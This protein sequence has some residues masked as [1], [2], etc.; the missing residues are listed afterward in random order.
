LTGAGI[1]LALAIGGWFVWG[2]TRPRAECGKAYLKVILKKAGLDIRKLPESFFDECVAHAEGCVSSYALA[3][4][5]RVY[6]NAEL[7]RFLDNVPQYLGIW[8][9]VSRVSNGAPVEGVPVAYN[10]IFPRYMA[11][12]YLALE[13]NQ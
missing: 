5:S 2:V 4:K 1:V 6:Q 13:R 12:L 3:G 9:D 10:Q 8:L 11:E 7:T